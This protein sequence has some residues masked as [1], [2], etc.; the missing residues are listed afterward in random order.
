[1]SFILH[2]QSIFFLSLKNIKNVS[3]ERDKKKTLVSNFFVKVFS[4]A[5]RYIYTCI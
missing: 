1:M 2:F 4:N 5:K 3:I